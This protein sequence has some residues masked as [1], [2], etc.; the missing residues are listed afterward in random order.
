METPL[1]TDSAEFLDVEEV[2]LAA[3]RVMP[4]AYRD[5]VNNRPF[6]RRSRCRP[7]ATVR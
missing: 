3:E 5:F 1:T 4:A 6:V 7:I 2:R